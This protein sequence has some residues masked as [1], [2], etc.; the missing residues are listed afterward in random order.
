MSKYQYLKNHYWNLCS[1]LKTLILLKILGS[2]KTKNLNELF[3]DCSS[4]LANFLPIL[5]IKE[6]TNRQVFINTAPVRIIPKGVYTSYRPSLP[7]KTFAVLLG[8][9]KTKIERYVI[10]DIGGNFITTID[11]KVGPIPFLTLYNFFQKYANLYKD[12]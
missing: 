2:E 5:V 8:I 11:H 7:G 10:L 12:F 1:P 4:S 3:C 9:L 6:K